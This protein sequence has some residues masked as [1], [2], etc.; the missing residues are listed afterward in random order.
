MSD[1][2]SLKFSPRIKSGISP[3][4]AFVSGGVET[5]IVD[6][7]SFLSFATPTMLFWVFLYFCRVKGLHFMFDFP[8]LFSFDDDNNGIL[9][10]FVDDFGNDLTSSNF[11]FTSSWCE[12]R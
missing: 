11:Y 2:L 4:I 8:L 9:S 6:A 12:I 10:V 1:P 3:I 5:S 7:E